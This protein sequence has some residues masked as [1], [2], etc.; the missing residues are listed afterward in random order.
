MKTLVDG[1]KKFQSEVFAAKKD[2]FQR[3]ALGQNPRAL[4]I[5]CSD[6]RID[7]GFDSDE[8]GD[9]SSCAMR[10]NIVPSYGSQIGAAARSIRHR[11]PRREKLSSAA[12][13]TRVMKGVLILLR[14]TS[15]A[16]EW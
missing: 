4:F 12:T 16:Q 14:K 2:L 6:S 8:P 10:A 13:R 11:H 1:V 9:C 5:T 7:P 15:I 3:L